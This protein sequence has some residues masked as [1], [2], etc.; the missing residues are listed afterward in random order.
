MMESKWIWCFHCERCFE[1]QYARAVDCNKNLPAD[2]QLPEAE[3]MLVMC[4]YDDCDGAE[5]DFWS[6]RSIRCVNHNYPRTPAFG[7]RYPM[8]VTAA[9]DGK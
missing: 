2:C 3:K 1:R 9:I 5:M 8:Y 6:W 4:A 7:V